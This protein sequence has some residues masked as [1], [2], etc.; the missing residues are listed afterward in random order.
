MK[1]LSTGGTG[2][3]VKRERRK[4]AFSMYQKYVCRDLASKNK[5][6]KI[7]DNILFNT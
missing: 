7:L 5:S 2:F 6:C 3:E 1:S 4:G